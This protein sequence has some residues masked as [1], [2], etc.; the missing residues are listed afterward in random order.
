MFAKGN[1]FENSLCGK[2]GAGYCSETNE[3][4]RFYWKAGFQRDLG[5]FHCGFHILEVST[6]VQLLTQIRLLII[7]GEASDL[8][9]I[10][11]HS[12]ALSVSI[13]SRVLPVTAPEHICLHTHTCLHTYACAC[14]TLPLHSSSCYFCP[15]SDVAW[16]SACWLGKC[17]E[18]AHPWGS[19]LTPKRGETWPLMSWSPHA[20]PCLLGFK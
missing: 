8:L 4:M 14:G 17:V 2:N 19:L 12:A 16:P 5:S 3:Y 15:P 7:H 18:E 20:I 6:L 11:I 13:V 10:L 9:S 1:G